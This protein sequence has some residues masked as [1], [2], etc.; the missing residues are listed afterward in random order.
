MTCQGALLKVPRDIHRIVEYTT[1]ATAKAMEYLLGSRRIIKT[2][3]ALRG[4]GESGTRA[5]VG[6]CTIKSWV[7]LRDQEQHHHDRTK[8]TITANAT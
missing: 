7:Q 2:H 5:I 6:S 4:V 1:T 8:L 3:K